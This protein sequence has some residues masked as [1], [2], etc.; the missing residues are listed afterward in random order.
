M[1][2]TNQ[3][4]PYISAALLGIALPT[5]ILGR[6]VLAVII[7]VVILL[8]VVD[9]IKTAS[10]IN[11]RNA[12]IA[13]W[14]RPLGILLAAVFILSIPSIIVAEEPLH[15]FIPPGRT[16]GFCFIATA[17]Y[18]YL[19]DRPNLSKIW[20][21]WLIISS[22]LAIALAYFSQFIRPELYWFLHLKGMKTEPL[23]HTLKEYTA[24][25]VFIIPLLIFSAYR[26]RNFL[27]VIALLSALALII[28]IWLI[29]NRATIA[30]LLAAIMCLSIAIG[31]RYGSKLQVIAAGAVSVFCLSGVLWWLYHTRFAMSLLAPERNYFLPTWL[32]DFQR[33]TIWSH[34]LD[35]GFLT[36]WFGRGA[37]TINLASGADRVLEG[38]HG[39]HVIPAHPHN[40][41]V[42]LFAE[43]GIF[44][45]VAVIGFIV[46]C[47]VRLLYTYRT[48]GHSAVLTAL[49]IFAGYWFSGLFNFSFWAAWWQLAFILAMSLVL[50]IRPNSAQRK[51]RPSP[52]T[53]LYP[54]HRARL[55]EPNIGDTWR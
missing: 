12:F 46:Y 17:F 6:S 44:G 26:S 47:M 48:S 28:L 1:T 52:E 8:L 33:Q 11:M 45:L 42:E 30:G 43:I 41:P 36:P 2:Q 55:S 25:A 7:C 18:V 3:T 15:S 10:F 22:V 53:R 38:T 23:G 50:S 20:M 21:K 19:K 13:E 51:S 24:L 39:L 34:A 40:W 5:L 9:V 14:K 27:S 32:I 4:L 29:A 16:L 49:A 31:A 35:I 37:N 54:N